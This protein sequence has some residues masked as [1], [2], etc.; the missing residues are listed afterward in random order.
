MAD[1][2]WDKQTGVGNS[3]VFE[4]SFDATNK[5]TPVL[6][7]D[8]KKSTT[9][10]IQTTGSATVDVL[11]YLEDPDNPSPKTF[12]LTS[13]AATE[14]SEDYVQSALSG[15]SGLDFAGTVTGGDTAVIQVLQTE[16]S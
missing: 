7:L 12:T 8:P 6:Q 11:A 9:I 16:R 10:A 1:V 2:T 13:G 14:S 15:I 5:T 4:V 3:D